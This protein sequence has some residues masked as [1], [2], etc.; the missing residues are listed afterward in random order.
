MGLPIAACGEGTWL[1]ASE[2]PPL[3]GTRV[4]VLLLGTGPKAAPELANLP[5]VL[6]QPQP[7]PAWPQYGGTP[8]HAP[9]H[10]AAAESLTRAWSVSIGSGASGSARLLSPPI[11]AEDRV[12][13]VDADSRVSA[14]SVAEGRNIWRGLPGKEESVDR[15]GGGGAAYGGGTVFSALSFGEVTARDASTGA[16][17]WRVLLKAPVRSA[18]T[19]IGDRLLIRTA[20]SQ[21]FALDAERGQIVWRHAGAVEQAGILGSAPPAATNRMA[22]AAYPSGEVHALDLT[23][24]RPIWSET[25]LRPRR[26]LAIGTINDITGAPVIDQD[27]VYVAGSGGEMACLSLA[28]G[29]RI[30]EVAI[31][32]LTTPWVAGNFI[33]VVTDRGELVCV[34]REK[35]GIRWVSPLGRAEGSS[36]ARTLWAGPTLV[37]DRLLLAGSNGDVISVSPYTGEILGKTS[38]GGRFSQPPVAAG[39]SVYVLG[40]DGRLTAFR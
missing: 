13:V 23:N 4:P 32:S 14:W 16:E 28:R 40:D 2:E 33:Y 22:I 8:D 20:D 19:I 29:E 27:R 30:W 26:T 3:P 15:L 37:S 21:L 12:Y 11:V 25:L 36:A 18:P 9:Q 10:L 5:V 35:G 38:V 34:L 1:G 24:G 17:L 39:G 7:N 6:P 31:A